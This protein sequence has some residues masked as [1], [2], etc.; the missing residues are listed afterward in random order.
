MYCIQK[1]IGP[2]EWTPL[3]SRAFTKF[4][5]RVL[6][7]IVPIVVKYELEHPESVQQTLAKRQMSE[8]ESLQVT[9]YPNNELSTDGFV[10]PVMLPKHST[11]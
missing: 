8:I 6:D 4:F 2:E 11:V 10:P 3:V 1:A 9:S 5:S 7:V